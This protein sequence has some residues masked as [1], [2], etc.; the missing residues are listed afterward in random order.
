MLVSSLV[1]Y[2]AIRMNAPDS[3]LPMLPIA[4]Y[5]EVAIGLLF[6]LEPDIAIALKVFGLRSATRVYNHAA[7]NPLLIRSL[8]RVWFYDD[9]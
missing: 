8:M 1:Q 9:F 3:Y 7:R 2:A 4:C 5:C 6:R